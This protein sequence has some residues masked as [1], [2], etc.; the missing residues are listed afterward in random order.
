MS[1]IVPASTL[2]TLGSAALGEY[3]MNTDRKCFNLNA[4]VSIISCR[5][6]NL[7][8]VNGERANPPAST[9][10]VSTQGGSSLGS[11]R[12]TGRVMFS[13]DKEGIS[14]FMN[15]QNIGLLLR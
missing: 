15:A 1:S 5:L 4:K 11:T 14:L 2:D 12:K 13:G 9:S 10:C 6:E 8:M 3:S 7:L